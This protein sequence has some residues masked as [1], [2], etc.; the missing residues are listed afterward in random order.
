MTHDEA[1]VAALVAGLLF[2]LLWIRSKLGS[3][4]LANHE[5]RLQ[6]LARNVDAPR[7]AEMSDVGDD[8][9][10]EEHQKEYGRCCLFVM[11][12]TLVSEVQ[13][14]WNPN[15]ATRFTLVPTLDQCEIQ[16]LCADFQVIVTTD[17]FNF[18]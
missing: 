14:G 7:S 11:E 3:L 5:A 2:P 6:K 8:V 4:D 10:S 18:S 1:I 9:V 12:T 17:V 13:A 16:V 15:G